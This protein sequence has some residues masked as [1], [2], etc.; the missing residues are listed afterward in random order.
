MR[1]WKTLF[2]NIV[3]IR[4][5][6]HGFLTIRDRCKRFRPLFDQVSERVWNA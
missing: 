2:I 1:A 5:F 4:C 6:L 3:V